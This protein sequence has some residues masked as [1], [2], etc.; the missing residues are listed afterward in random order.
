[1]KK[2]FLAVAAVLLTAAALAAGDYDWTGT[3]NGEFLPHLAGGYFLQIFASG[4]RC[5]I[6]LAFILFKQGENQ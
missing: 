3:G 1:M 5:G 6:M 2:F 4:G